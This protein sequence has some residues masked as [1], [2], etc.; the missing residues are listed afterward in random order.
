MHIQLQIQK[1][2]LRYGSYPTGMVRGQDL[3][4][5]SICNIVIGADIS[6]SGDQALMNTQ[7]QAHAFEH[8]SF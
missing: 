7:G 2:I 5:Y 1:D 4:S 6:L 8:C 3:Q